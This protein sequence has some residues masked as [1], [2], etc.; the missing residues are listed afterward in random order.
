VTTRAVFTAYL[1]VII[2]GLLYS[3]VVGLLQQ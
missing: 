2:G 1:V 3:I